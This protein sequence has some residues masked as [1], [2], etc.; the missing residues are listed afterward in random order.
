MAVVVDVMVLGKC[1]ATGV[2][3]RFRRA[4]FSLYAAESHRKN[5]EQVKVLYAVSIRSAAITS[6]SVTLR[7]RM[8]SSRL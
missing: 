1:Q 7:G 4:S 5:H 2:L 6:D 3:T 8:K